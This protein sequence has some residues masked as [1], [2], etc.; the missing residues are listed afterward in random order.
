MICKIRLFFPQNVVQQNHPSPVGSCQFQQLCVLLCSSLRS[1]PHLVGMG[2]HYCLFNCA[3]WIG[4][5]IASHYPQ[6]HSGRHC[7]SWIWCHTMLV[8]VVKRMMMSLSLR[9][10]WMI[11]FFVV[12][13]LWPSSKILEG[14]V[15]CVGWL[16][17]WQIVSPSVIK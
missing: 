17:Q 16:Y 9:Y 10:C 4:V 7:V 13:P 3:Q 14:Q 12:I 15:Q 6:V 5:C 2:L 1:L 8:S 11:Q